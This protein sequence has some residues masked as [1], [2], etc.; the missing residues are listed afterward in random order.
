MIRQRFLNLHHL[1]PVTGTQ[2]NTKFT[3]LA[4]ISSI[5][6]SLSIFPLLSFSLFPVLFLP[7]SVSSTHFDYCNQFCKQQMSKQSLSS[8]KCILQKHKILSFPKIEKKVYF[9]FPT[10]RVYPE[11]TVVAEWF[12]ACVK[13]K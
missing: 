8:L 13:F 5:Y 11:P 1:T 9:Y 10:K 4:Y 12:R 3:G 7:L 6:L 2:R